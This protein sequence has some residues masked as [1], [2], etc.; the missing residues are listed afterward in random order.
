M[1][2]ISSVQYPSRLPRRNSES[3]RTRSAAEHI[4]HHT[5]DADTYCILEAIVQLWH[6]IMQRR[7]RRAVRSY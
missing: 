1:V 5:G 6:E 7:R 3:R 2:G 4:P